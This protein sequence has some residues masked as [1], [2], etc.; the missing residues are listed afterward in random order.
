[1]KN[2]KEM[3]YIS[4]KMLKRAERPCIPTSDWVEAITIR[5]RTLIALK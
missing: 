2:I 3:D 4:K 1:M 5:A